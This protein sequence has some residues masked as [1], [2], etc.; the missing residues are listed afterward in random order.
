VSSL[1]RGRAGVDTHV[2]GI[3]SEESSAFSSSH[4]S[5]VRA[6]PLADGPSNILMDSSINRKIEN[7]ENGASGNPRVQ[8]KNLVA[9]TQ[10]HWGPSKIYPPLV[11]PPN[12]SDNVSRQLLGVFVKR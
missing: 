4:G 5:S 9:E 3:G 11:P 12:L 7:C 6:A 2:L 8:V 1:A 10:Q